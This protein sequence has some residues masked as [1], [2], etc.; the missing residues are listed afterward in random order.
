MTVCAC[1]LVCVRV[2]ACVCFCVSECTVCVCECGLY[3]YVCI[4]GRD[5]GGEVVGICCVAG[6]V[7]ALALSLPALLWRRSAPVWAPGK[8]RT[9]LQ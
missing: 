2:H 6:L 4:L 1:V 9:A 7:P 8:H 5:G 3:I